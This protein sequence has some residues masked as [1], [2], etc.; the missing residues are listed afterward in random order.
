MA[1]VYLCGSITNKSYQE[2]V[3]WR[4][5][6]TDYLEFMGHSALCPMRGKE[7]IR[8]LEIIPQALPDVEGC[9]VDQIF[10]RDIQDIDEADM[11]FAYLPDLEVQPSIGSLVEMGYAYAKG[12]PII[13]YVP[14]S[15]IKHPF[16]NGICVL[17]THNWFLALNTLSEVIDSL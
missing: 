1:K 14:E 9:D 5:T 7:H 8:H 2:A 12:K 10:S 16:I 17:A 6:I 13:A 11:L 15:K 3:F 4:H